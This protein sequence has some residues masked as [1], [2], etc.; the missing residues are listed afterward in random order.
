MLTEVAGGWGRKES[1]VPWNPIQSDG[2]RL[3]TIHYDKIRFTIQISVKRVRFN[4]IH[5]DSLRSSPIDYGA[6]PHLVRCPIPQDT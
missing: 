3:N 4:T 1:F 5:Y 2:V 6:I